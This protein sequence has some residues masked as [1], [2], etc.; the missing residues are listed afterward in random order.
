MQVFGRNDPYDTGHGSVDGL[1]D[2]LL[3]MVEDGL[4]TPAVYEPFIFPVF[5]RSLQELLLP[6]EESGASEAF[7]VDK[8]EARECRVPF[9]EEFA[10]SGDSRLWAESFAGL[11]RAFSEPVVVAAFPST[12]ERPQLVNELY[13]R[14][15]AR[16]ASDP[17]RNFILFRWLC[18]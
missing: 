10:R 16:F 6:P 4:L 2:A 17:H 11:I 1:S 7:R 18:F 14:L 3:D 9:N 13:R 8:A 5:Y 12:P 15:V